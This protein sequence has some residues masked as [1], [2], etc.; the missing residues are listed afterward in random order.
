MEQHHS[1]LKAVNIT[2][3]MIKGKVE[4][5]PV[6]ELRDMTVEELAELPLAEFMRQ[7]VGYFL[8]VASKYLK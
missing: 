8:K 4:A 1:Q 5:K 7:P 2:P 3:E 6:K